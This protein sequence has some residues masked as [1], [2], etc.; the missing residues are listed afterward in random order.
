MGLGDLCQHLWLFGGV[1]DGDKSMVEALSHKHEVTDTKLYSAT[2]PEKV[3]T[4][5]D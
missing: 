3:P 4:S 5:S 2:C 1:R